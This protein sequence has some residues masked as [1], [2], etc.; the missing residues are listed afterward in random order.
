MQTSNRQSYLDWLRIL[1][2]A[3]VLFFHSAMPF[4]E[5]D[6]HIKNTEHSEMLQEF[7]FFISRFRMP[8]LF[9]I[10]GA[11]AYFMLKNRS[12]SQ[13]VALRFRRLLIPLVFGML[14]IVPIQV[15]LERVNQGFKG[16][17]FQFY[18]SVFTT[19]A[20]PKGNLSWHH[21]WFIAY[22]FV[23]DVLFA[24]YLRHASKTNRS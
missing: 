8:L 9:F 14:L 4:V 2:I 5:F 3:G 13:F 10:S 20:Y 24:P 19:G 21:L 22:L 17:F 12:S 6:W 23:Y 11:V 1:A 16:N 18:H 7:N 15:Y